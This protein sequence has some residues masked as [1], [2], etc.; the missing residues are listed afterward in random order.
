MKKV[1]KKITAIILTVTLLAVSFPMSIFAVDPLVTISAVSDKDYVST[2]DKF[3]MSVNVGAC[4]EGLLSMWV[5]LNYDDTLI[6]FDS[7]KQ[8]ALGDAFS[9]PT[10]GHV[11]SQTNI[12]GI[13]GGASSVGT[14]GGVLFT[15]TFEVIATTAT[16]T[17]N[18]APVL[19]VVEYYDGDETE[20]TVDDETMR[21]VQAE[22]FMAPTLVSITAPT[23]ILNV[24]NGTPKTAT[25]LGLPT[26]VKMVTNL[27]EID[28]DVTWDVTASSYNVGVKTQQVFPVSGTVTLPD[29]VL[30]NG[31]SLTT[32]ISV[33]VNGEIVT[34]VSIP[35][36]VEPA[37]T[38]ITNGTAKNATALGLPTTVAIVTDKYDTGITA[39]VVWDV[40]SSSYNPDEK[41]E[42]TFTVDGTV[43]LPDNVLN[44]APAVP[45]TT[46]ISVTVKKALT[47]ESITAPDAI[48]VA[49]GTAKTATALGLPTEV[50]IVVSDG[51]ET[52]MPATVVWE[53]DSSSY[54]PT[55]KTVQTFDVDGTITLPVGVYDNGIT[56]TTT[57]S[58]TV[59][60]APNLVSIPAPD[61][62]IVVNGTAKENLLPAT[63][64][65]IT[66][67]GNMQADVV[68]DLDLVEYDSSIK[69]EQ[70]FLVTGTVILPDSI[71][72]DSDIITE[73]GIVTISVTVSAF[74]ESNDSI[75]DIIL[76]AIMFIPNL[77]FK[78]FNTIWSWITGFFTRNP[79]AQ[80]SVMEIAAT[81]PN[82]AVE[83]VASIITDN[84]NP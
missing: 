45:L 5:K 18:L 84:M 60:K 48:T 14:A 29:G 61:A 28:A 67:D 70:T 16:L 12:G 34:L 6:K 76:K 2:G 49:N 68:W 75:F 7:L 46:S 22:I 83:Y 63:I 78:G 26:T 50:T 80:G 25:E 11:L 52:T 21:V 15:V 17:T 19:E 38:G 35:P 39:T 32:T 57:I 10:L 56:L 9:Y 51:T 77:I 47:V 65:I 13:Y 24:A 4:Q 27:G 59:K 81:D 53:V 8:G 71:T 30:Q 44:P 73:Q 72:D 62:I 55:L 54:D 43:T 33:T 82:A 66:D 74:E 1:F 41:T 69:E 3:T 23:A 31:V 20:Y 37:I 58:V 36:V 64:T 42:Q 79:S 40:A